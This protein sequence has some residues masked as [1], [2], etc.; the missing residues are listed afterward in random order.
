MHWIARL[1]GST[2]GKKYLM[3]VTGILLFAYVVA[4]LLGNLQ[5]FLGPER[6]NNYAHFLH[7]VPRLLWTARIILLVAVLVHIVAAVQLFFQNRRGRPIPYKVKRY[8]AADYA[9]RTM[10]WSGP[11]IAAFVVYHLLDLTTGTL[12]PGFTPDNVYHNVV[13]S[14]QN[15]PVALAYM[16]A[17]VL[18]GFH[19]YHGLWSMLQSLGVSHPRYDA[20]RKAFA[21]V[22]SLA[23]ATGNVAIPLAVLTGIVG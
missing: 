23:I 7:S 22:F 10:V 6:L 2:L 15:P 11:I 4:H 5:I 3:A 12:H 9:A 20:W 19:L 21:V 18:L 14:F 1:Y 17:N 13:T 16:V 8:E